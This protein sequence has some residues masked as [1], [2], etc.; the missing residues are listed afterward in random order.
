MSK[1]ELFHSNELKNVALNVFSYYT[2]DANETHLSKFEKAKAEYIKNLER[3]ISCA[4]SLSIKDF[5]A[6]NKIFQYIFSGDR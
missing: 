6:S 2:L 4:N 3:Y 5:E 1:P